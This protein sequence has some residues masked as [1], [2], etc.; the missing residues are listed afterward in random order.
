MSRPTFSTAWAAALDIYD[1]ADAPGKVA[2]VI[3]GMIA[4]NIL[5]VP[6]KERWENT[7]AVRMSYIL[8]RSGVLIPGRGSSTVSGR[9]GRRY[10]YRVSDL[11]G[12]LKERWGR[13]DL[14]LRFPPPTELRLSV[15]RGIILFEVAGWNTARGHA[16][17]WSGRRCYDD[18][19]FDAG[20]GPVRT[21]R[22]HFWR[23]K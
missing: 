7:C 8:N 21:P 2:R 10:F 4:H 22:A 9:D 11:I 19:Y 14:M 13:P 23:L 5:H 6:E 15:E 12:F 18:C 20:S 1:P 16:T 17:L 3:G